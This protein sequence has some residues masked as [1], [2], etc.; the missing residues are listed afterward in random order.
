MSPKTS[1]TKKKGGD[2][3]LMHLLRD[4]TRTRSALGVYLLNEVQKPKVKTKE[5]YGKLQEMG[6]EAVRYRDLA[7]LLK[8]YK[9]I[10]HVK[11]LVL[12]RGY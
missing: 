7:W 2:R 10:D 8:N 3:D 6:Y 4:A 11:R 1:K 12:D 5:I 9:K